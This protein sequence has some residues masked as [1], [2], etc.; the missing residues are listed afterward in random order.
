M[1]AGE[2]E[3]KTPGR[4]SP[5]RGPGVAAPEARAR[6]GPRGGADAGLLPDLLRRGLALGVTGLFA[7]EEALR[8]ALGDGVPREWI[9]FFLAQGERTRSDLVERVS[10]ELGRALSG[11]DPAEILRRL[12]DGHTLEVSAQIRLREGGAGRRR[13]RG[14]GRRPGARGGAQ[15]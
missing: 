15:A 9:E 6:G 1:A 11:A 10:R 2:G 7:T 13:A 12:L 4:R 14:A 5:G 8:R 3:R